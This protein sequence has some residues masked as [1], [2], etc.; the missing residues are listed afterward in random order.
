VQWC[1]GNIGEVIFDPWMAEMESKG[2]K[3]QTSTYVTGFELGEDK[4]N[5]S[6]VTCKESDGKTMTLEADEVVFA[7]GAKALNAF[8][9]N[10]PELAG[11]EEFRR[12]ANLRG[13]SVLATRVFLDKDVRVPYSANACWGFD[14]GVGMTVFDIKA[15]HGE[16]ART[17][18]GAPGSVL[19]VDY[20]HASKLLVMSDDD[21]VSKVKKDLDNILKCT[22][23]SVVDAAV[24][25]LP[26]AVN[27]YY[28]GSYQDMP[29]V[30]STSLDNLHFCGDI[31]R[32][33]HGSWSQEKAYVTGMEAA[34]SIMKKPI[35][36]GV[37]PVPADEVHV[38]L[39]KNLVATA[40]KIIAGCSPSK[41]A[42][43]L[44]DFLW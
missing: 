9:S 4:K 21:I 22:S 35:D 6:S 1:R 17:V 26:S 34:N 3:F 39:G 27:W 43:S 20:Y 8:V 23:A 2:V 14:D 38:A 16:N 10:S 42:P 13:T 37:L 25:R 41:K 33:R 40:R 5:I 11:F 32:T 15:L 44:V 7:V 12:F 36:V 31:V 18:E 24:V 30:K 28:P 29:D 19:E